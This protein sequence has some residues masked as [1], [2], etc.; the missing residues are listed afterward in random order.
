MAPF[1]GEVRI[2]PGAEPVRRIRRTFLAPLEALGQEHLADPAAP[3]AD[4]LLAEI[5]DQAIQRPRGEGQ[6]QLRRT[7]QGGLDHR[8]P[9]LGR[10]GGWRARA[11][12]LFQPR[13]AALVEPL[14]PKPDR[15]TAQAHPGGDLGGAQ[16]L[17]HSV[18]HDLRPSNKAGTERARARH[19]CQFVGFVIAQRSHSKGHGRA[20]EQNQAPPQRAEGQKA[21][22]NL[23]DAPLR[24]SLAI[25]AILFGRQPES[26]QKMGR[27]V[28]SR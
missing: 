17:L 18:P 20:P 14:E 4:A 13:Q 22:N 2:D 25:R 27:L 9:L 21:A 7:T 16:A 23:P 19:P 15:G 10:V 3:H 1:F 28:P 12:V 5:G 6:A 26:V 24:R 11:H 8:A